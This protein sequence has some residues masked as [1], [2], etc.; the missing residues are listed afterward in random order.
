MISLLLND[1]IRFNFNDGTL[2]RADR[3]TSIWFSSGSSQKYPWET[4]HLILVLTMLL[5][6]TCMNFNIKMIK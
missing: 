4:Q 2:K 3:N 6:N 1:L 5:L